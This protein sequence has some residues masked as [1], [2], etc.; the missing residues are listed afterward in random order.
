M[1]AFVLNCPVELIDTKELYIALSNNKIAGVALDV[2]ECEE[3][4]CHNWKK[5][6]N[7]I[8]FTSH[9]LKK[10]FFIQKMVQLPNVLI[11]PHNAYNTIE[12]QKRILDITLGNIRSS[13]NINDGANNLVLI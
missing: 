4:L 8:N 13:F 1:K 10:F 6:M 12:A 7:N 2:V 5:C 11:T 9:C 3:Y